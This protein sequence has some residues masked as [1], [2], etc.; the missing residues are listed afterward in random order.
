MHNLRITL[1]GCLLLLAGLGANAATEKYRL[2][3]STDN[4]ATSMTIAWCQPSGS[5]P[6]VCYGTSDLGTNWS[7]YPNQHAPDRSVDS[8]KGMNH[9]F[10]RLTGLL[11]NTAYYFVIKDSE[12]NSNRYWFKTLPNNPEQQLSVVAGGDSRSNQ[13]PRQKANQM[14]SKLRPHFVAFGGDMVENGTNSE[15]Q[16]WM[17]D[18]QLTI[19]PDGRMYPV[20]VTRGNHESENN[21]LYNMF[22]TPSAGMYFATSFG[23]GLLRLYTLN[24]EV[25]VGGTQGNW[26]VN[27]L[28][29]HQS[30]TQ[31]R[32]AQYHRCTRPH[33]TVKPNIEAQYNAWSVPFYD[34]GV[35]LV[36]ECDAHVVKNTYPIVPSYGAGNDEGFVRDDCEGTVYIGEGCWGAPLR[37]NNYN[38]TWTRASG[39]FNEFKWLFINQNRIE[40]RTIMVDNASLVASVTDAAPFTPPAN[41]QLWTMPDGSNTL[42]ID[43]YANQRPV[44][45]VVSPQPGVCYANSGTIHFSVNATDPDGTVQYVQFYANGQLLST[46]Y[47]PPYTLTWTPGT[48]GEQKIRIRAV[49]NENICSVVQPFSVYTY[50]KPVN[51]KIVTPSDDAEQIGSGMDLNDIDLDLGESDYI[52]LRFTNLQI[53]RGVRI[54]NAY[55]DFMVEEL[56][57]AIGS[58]NIKAENSDN[59]QPFT[60][61]ANN[62]SNRPLTAASVSWG[63][64]TW[65]TAGSFQ[66]TP[67]LKDMVQQVVNRAGWTENSALVLMVTGATVGGRDAIAADASGTTVLRIEYDF[68]SPA[69]TPP[70]LGPDQTLCDNQPLTLD[71]GAGYASYLWNN[72]P[73][74]TTQTLPINSSGIYNVSVT[75]NTMQPVVAT[76]QVVVTFLPVADIN[77]G[78]VIQTCFNGSGVLLDAGS[79]FEVY[80]WSTGETTPA[81]VVNQPGTYS[82]LAMDFN[83]CVVTDEV[84]VQANIQPLLQPVITSGS[85]LHVYNLQPT[86]G[87]P[88]YTY[89][90]NNTGYVNY[91]QM[92]GGYVRLITG[93]SAVINVTITDANGCSVTYINSI[94]PVSGNVPQITAY[95]ITPT[96]SEA[97]ANGGISITVSGGTPPYSFNWSNGSTAQNVT[98]LAKGWYV[99]TVTDVLGNS[100]VGWYWVAAGYNRSKN[101]SETTQLTIMPNP[102]S[103]MAYLQYAVMEQSNSVQI[104][105][106]GINGQPVQQFTGLPAQGLLPFEGSNL[107]PGVYWAT[108]QSAGTA[109][110]VK[111]KFVVVR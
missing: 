65:T 9:R 32:I 25:V 17:N 104:T 87:T 69:F 42:T 72:N 60:S 88:P 18:W 95:T 26:L 74:F 49:D 5:A 4:T 58:V 27:D 53:P 99:V 96:A 111:Q 2:V 97:V 93:N 50:S 101:N 67:N 23:G 35:Q 64:A 108:L 7:L 56:S 14:V 91:Q 8:Y 63:P 98:G 75:Y 79:A 46:D 16:E 54:L 100:A 30:N 89:A 84:V 76:D 38:R 81:I 68:N 19:S 45:S 86:G 83:G 105:I 1:I 24:T 44:V 66:T 22:D 107:P 110:P 36:V 13:V 39:S 61:A 41:L 3:W 55:L 52:G 11:P 48:T 85:F 73:A 80:Y 47:T 10:A 51:T 34:Y 106:Y 15:W 43:A 78:N 82:V 37:N 70:Y 92:P 21:I 20:V 62:L 29:A 57:V 71:A 90:W 103:N 40:V 6:I 12:G 28:Q 59:A 33:T 77:L 31:W 109:E 94:N 102:V